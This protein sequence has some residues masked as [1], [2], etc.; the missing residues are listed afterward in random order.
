M[1][2]HARGLLFLAALAC[3]GAQSSPVRAESLAS[4]FEQ[5]NTA[6]W[7]GDFA[8]A[9]ALYG[10]IEDLGARSA[11]LSYNRATAEAR[12]GNLGRAIQHYERV[13][14]S[15]PGHTDTLHNLA[16]I[17]EF[18]AKR[19]SEAGRDADLAPALGPWRAVLD[20][21]S[22]RS[23]ALTFLIFHLALFTVLV[24]RRFVRAEGPHLA[25]G[26]TS[27][28][29]LL[30]AVATGAVTVGKYRQGE[31]TALEAV[32]VE[33]DSLPVMEGPA[34]SARRFTIEEGSRVA[35]LEHHDEWTRIR[36]DQGRDGWVLAASLGII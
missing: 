7:N 23:A 30:L 31:G 16:L 26:V 27:G 25:L 2:R 12:L 34:S 20:R 17:R 6:F 19:A 32:V 18:I 29:L 35:L 8:K 22:P 5:A 24:S 10:E 9:A 4:L 1:T 3:A 28:I 13:L 15:D 21:F 33:R 11:S 36:D 14:R